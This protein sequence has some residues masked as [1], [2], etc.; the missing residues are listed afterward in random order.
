MI[1]LRDL[2]DVE[3]KSAGIELAQPVTFHIRAL[4]AGGSYGWTY[5]SNDMF[6]YGWIIDADTRQPVWTMDVE[7]TSAVHNDREFDGT[8]RLNRGSYEVYFAAC[9]FTYHSMFTHMNTDVDHRNKPL[10]G[11]SESG[12]DHFFS[13]FS[14]LFSNDITKEWK[15]RAPRWGIE[16]LVDDTHASSVRTFTPPKVIG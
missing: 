5:Q 11:P 8:V 13:F 3:I 12:K 10:F 14:N 2:S 15:K 6:A 1:S 4:G 16:L 7:N 9:T